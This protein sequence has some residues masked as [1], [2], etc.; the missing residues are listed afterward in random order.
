MDGRWW[1]KREA[2]RAGVFS[3]FLPLPHLRPQ[4]AQQQAPHFR[5]DPAVQGQPLGG[6]LGLLRE[7]ERE[8]EGV[9]ERDGKRAGGG[10]MKH[11][12]DL[13][14]KT[15]APAHPSNDSPSPASSPV[16][17]SLAPF[18]FPTAR[19]ARSSGSGPQSG[20]PPAAWPPPPA[21]RPGRTGRRAG[22]T[23]AARSA[24]PRPPG[25]RPR[26]GTGRRPGWG[27]GPWGEGRPCLS[28]EGGRDEE[29][30][31][32]KGARGNRPVKKGSVCFCLAHAR[33]GWGRALAYWGVGVRRAHACACSCAAQGTRVSREG[34][35]RCNETSG[36]S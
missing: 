19:P 33:G 18:C 21:P 1:S 7:R 11:R 35:P 23:P 3:F 9:R 34:R 10:G 20:G 12:T 14:A 5:L 17:C 30:K 2:R 22:W 4:R 24:G 13:H 15:P 28:L 36:E 8:R 31:K 26:P 32:K 6:E 25:A 16:S 29:R 27:S